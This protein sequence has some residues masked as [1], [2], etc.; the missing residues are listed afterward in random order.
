MGIRQIMEPVFLLSLP[1]SGST[2]VQRVLAC[3]PDIAT[4][5]EPWLLLP[6]VYALRSDGVKSEY[7]HQT[8]AVALDDFCGQLPNKTEDYLSE[9]REMTLRLYSKVSGEATYFLDKTPRYHLILDELLLTFPTCK[10]IILWRNPL[11]IAASMMETWSKGNWNLHRWFHIDLFNGLDNL[12]RTYEQNQERI[13]A[14]RFEDFVSEPDIKH[15]E[16]LTFLQ[17]PYHDYATDRFSDISLPGRMGDPTGVKEYR[18]VSEESLHK[19]KATMTNP[20]RKFWSRRYLRW[21]G[22]NRL[23]TMG[24]PMEELQGELAAVPA[25]MDKLLFDLVLVAYGQIYRALQ[26]LCLGK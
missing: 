5:S 2:L 26:R 18:K 23:A 19:W 14:M 22:E 15:R 9:I 16:L 25:T 24:Y 21:I 13:F 8:M 11:A 10:I 17:L 7:N 4:T 20:W 12:V 3:H 1:R 6:L